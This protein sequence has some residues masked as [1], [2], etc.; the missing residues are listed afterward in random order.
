MVK[1]RKLILQLLQNWCVKG[2]FFSYIYCD[3][4]TLL[5]KKL[6]KKSKIKEMDK[7]L[8]HTHGESNNNKKGKSKYRYLFVRSFFLCRHINAV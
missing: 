3:L 4:F 7:E 8:Q 6:Q 5:E 2:E 1:I